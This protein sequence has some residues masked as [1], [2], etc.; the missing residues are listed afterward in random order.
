MYTDTY[1][2]PLLADSHCHM[3]ESNT[4]LKSNYPPINKKGKPL[5]LVLSPK[6]EPS[7]RC[8]NNLPVAVSDLPWHE[9]LPLAGSGRLC[10]FSTRSSGG[11]WKARGS[12]TAVWGSGQCLTFP[13]EEQEASLILTSFFLEWHFVS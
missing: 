11:A 5:S 6:Q 1:I 13:S 3:A 2:H 8:H 10:S 7:K 12:G 9:P 4:T